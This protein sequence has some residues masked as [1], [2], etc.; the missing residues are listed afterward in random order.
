[1]LKDQGWG[2]CL[3][4][5]QQGG[6]GLI[7]QVS[8]ASLALLHVSLPQQLLVFLP[9]GAELHLGI[10]VYVFLELLVLCLSFPVP[11][12]ELL[13]PLVQLLAPGLSIYLPPNNIGWEQLWGWGRQ[14]GAATIQSHV[15]EGDLLKVPAWLTST[16]DSILHFATLLVIPNT[17]SGQT[18]AGFQ[19]PQK[20]KGDLYTLCRA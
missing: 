5:P 19:G 6:D 1:M 17:L 11:L 15:G 10:Y 3:S 9:A 2:V 13:L 12:G 4:W 20:R 18:R 16:P 14:E 8:G 7:P